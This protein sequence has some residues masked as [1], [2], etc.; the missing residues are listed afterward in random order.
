MIE[1]D[2][3]T[4]KKKLG[5]NAILAVSL[6]TARASAQVQKLSLAETIAHLYGTKEMCMPVPF[7]NIVNGGEHADNNLDIQEFMIAPV[8]ANSF[9]EALRMGTEVFMTLKSILKKKKMPTTV[10][11]EGGFAPNFRS[12]EE[13]LS[14]V[15]EAIDACG[16]GANM[17][18]ALDVAASSFYEDGRYNLTQSG[19]G[20]RTAEQMYEYYGALVEDFPI[21]SIEDPL[22]ED[23]WKAWK[24]LTAKLPNIQIVGDDLFVT[25]TERLERGLKEKCANAIL[26]KLNQVGSLTETLETMKLAE[27][28][29]YK[30]MVSHRSG[31]TEDTFIADLAVGTGSG[32]I[33]TGSL[34]RSDRTA[35]YNRLLLLEEDLKVSY[36]GF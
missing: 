28:N 16:Y 19:K 9:S 1:L 30:C 14:I 8:Q 23:D 31:E 2:G 7:M 36:P 26:I 27:N 11:D 33:K 4:Q 15:R 18:L 21:V 29:K 25:Q 32:Q 10:G 35:K 20:Y 22:F 3:S 12:H 5:A 17:R 6:A 24:E 34:S 13:A